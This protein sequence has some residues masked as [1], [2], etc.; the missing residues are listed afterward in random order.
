MDSLDDLLSR[1]AAK[2]DIADK[3]TELELIQK[4]VIRIFPDNVRAVQVKEETL[5]IKTSNSAVAS[6][7]RLQQTLL[8]DAIKGICD[9]EITRLWIRQ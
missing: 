3:Q 5:V 9:P 4:E 1:K 2:L 7:V 8:L 6:D